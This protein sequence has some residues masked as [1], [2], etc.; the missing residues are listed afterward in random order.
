MDGKG[1]TRQ[2]LGPESPLVAA[3]ATL[4]VAA[5]FQPARRRVQAAVDRRFNR[6][7][8]DAARMTA[9]TSAGFDRGFVSTAGSSPEP[10][11]AI[12]HSGR[13]S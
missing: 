11:L 6:R 8:H 1:E 12:G 9:P 10:V 5:L 4:A 7:R 3:A 13:L 2:L